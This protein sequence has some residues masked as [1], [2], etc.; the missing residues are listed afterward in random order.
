MDRNVH[1][2]DYLAGPEAWK[3][4]RTT[5]VLL[6]RLSAKPSTLNSPILAMASSVT[7]PPGMLVKPSL[8]ASQQADRCRDVT[9]RLPAQVLA[10]IFRNAHEDLNSTIHCVCRRWH[11]VFQKSRGFQ[12]E[13]GRS[14]VDPQ[15][16]LPMELMAAILDELAWQDV[17][18]CSQVSRAW[19]GLSHTSP[20]FWRVRMFDIE[21]LATD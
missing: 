21:T 14:L 18:T 4:R 19:R 10:L 15:T 7:V 6:D 9:A 16:V 5:L 3:L 20:L 1:I 2:I 17:F 8:S 13:R 11:R 12:A